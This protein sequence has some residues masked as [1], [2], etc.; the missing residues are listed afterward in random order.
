MTKAASSSK[1]SVSIYQTR[2]LDGLSSRRLEFVPGSV[3]VG[4]V[5]DKVALGQV[6][7]RVLCFFPANIIP[8]WLS[9]LIYRMGNEQQARWWPQFGDIVSPPPTWT[10]RS[11][12]IQRWSVST[13]PH[14]A[15]PQKAV[16]VL[17][18]DSAQSLRQ[19][20]I[21][22]SRY[23]YSVDTFENRKH[24]YNFGHCPPSLG[25]PGIVL[26]SAVQHEHGTPPVTWRRK[27]NQFPKRHYKTKMNNI[28]NLFVVY[29][30]RLS[31]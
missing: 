20:N 13:R 3:H 1:T 15:T 2:G 27:K 6:S 22:C 17:R 8:P 11:P 23:W 14:S 30:T 12:S 16:I 21:F 4:C 31:Q 26:R 7:F 18:M 19:I 28:Q 9:I 29:F 25:T 10:T 5:V 24:V